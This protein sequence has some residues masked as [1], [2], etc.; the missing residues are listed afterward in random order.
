MVKDEIEKD[1]YSRCFYWIF[2]T[3]LKILAGAIRQEKVIKGTHFGKEEI[4][5]SLFTNNML[6]YVENPMEYPWKDMKI[7]KL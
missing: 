6:I 5:L 2:S 7:N 4:T 3:L 1:F